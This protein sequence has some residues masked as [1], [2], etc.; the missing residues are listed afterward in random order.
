MRGGE[1]VLEQLCLMFPAAPIRCLV[2]AREE[3]SEIIKRHSISGSLLQP[4]RFLHR[5]Y[6]QLLPFHPFA[7]SRMAVPH[8]TKLVVSSDASMIKGVRVPEDCLLVCYC[9]SPPRYIWEMADQYANKNA[10]MGALAQL[11]FRLT[12][13][14]CKRF[15][16]K[17]A[18]RVD[19]FI[20][21]SAFV[22]DR[23]RKFYQR[24]SVVVHPPVEID[25][26]DCTR[27]R[28]GSYLVV[29]ELVP[30]KRV[31]LAIEAFNKNG[32]PLI[33]IGDGPERKR[34]EQLAGDNITMLGRQPF[35]VL[36][37]H[38]ET[39][40]AF[41]FPGLEDF[42]ITPLEAQAS[43]APVLAFGQ[44]GALET[45]VNGQ[46]GIY[47]DTQSVESL[48]GAVAALESMYEQRGEQLS[49]DCRMNAE[50]FGNQRFRREIHAAI[51]NLIRQRGGE[52]SL[53]PAIEAI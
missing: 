50:R 32:L 3:L 23:I 15:D 47:F 2:F 46:T 30:Y 4:M 10:G 41:V 16:A 6:K 26:F 11:A 31:D 7:I 17:S 22:A 39:C 38:Y 35:N 8:S 49:K 33:V 28:S 29:S 48:N 19:L 43:G 40:R 20:A 13:P 24:D 21:N 18:N 1:K 51:L 36:K 45:V 25:E 42:G 12:I 14:K 52:E 37:E 9:H 27:Q 44:G 5:F 34:L 53:L